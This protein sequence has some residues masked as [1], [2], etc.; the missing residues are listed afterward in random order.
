MITR[1]FDKKSMFKK[2]W[3]QL[4]LTDRVVINN[5][6]RNEFDNF[7]CLTQ[8]PI[9]YFQVPIHAKFWQYWFFFLCGT[10]AE[11]TEW[12]ISFSVVIITG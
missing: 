12:F 8:I 9:F 6:K 1:Q 11:S 2:I 4:L 5:H 3:H 10:R 7:F